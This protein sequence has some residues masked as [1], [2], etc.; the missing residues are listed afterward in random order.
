ML[1]IKNC[2]ISLYCHFNKII[3]KPGASFQSSILSQKYARNICLTVYQYLAK[4]LFQS[5]QDS[6]EISISG[7]STTNNASDDVTDFKICGFHESAKLQISREQNIFLQ[8]KKMSITKPCTHLHR[9][10]SNLH[11]AHFNLHPAHS[12]LQPALCI[13]LNV[14]RTNISHA[15]RLRN[16]KLSILTEKW[17]TW[18]LGG[19]DS[20]SAQ[21]LLKF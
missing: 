18:S 19:A 17:H 20:K 11:P 1:T 4:F 3:K 8:I 21:R 2:Q 7:N 14:I 15:V 12:S 9:A 10:N 13:T 16:S 5:A 6:K